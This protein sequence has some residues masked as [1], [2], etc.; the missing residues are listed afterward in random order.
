MSFHGISIACGWTLLNSFGLDV[1]HVL[2]T[3]F[4]A[5]V[6]FL[7]EV[8]RR[9]STHPNFPSANFSV[10]TNSHLVGSQCFICLASLAAT[11]ISLCVTLRS[12]PSEVVRRARKACTEQ[13]NPR[14]VAV[15]ASTLALMKSS[16]CTPDRF[17]NIWKAAENPRAM[18]LPSKGVKQFSKGQQ[19][20]A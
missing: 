2:G 4:T 18:G 6:V 9:Q 7:Q 19:A 17:N 12:S 3:R 20:G 15:K 10:F 8:S 5:A 14:A 16:T 1:I 11:S 13:L